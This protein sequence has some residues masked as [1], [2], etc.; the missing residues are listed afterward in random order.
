MFDAQLLFPG[1]VPATGIKILGPWFPKQ[2][3]HARIT[4]EV[5]EVNGAT[6]KVELFTKNSEDAGDGTN[7]DSGGV[8][9]NITA[10]ATGRTTQEWYSTG[11]IALKEMVRYRFTV[12][13]GV[14]S[15]WVLF[16][17]LSPVWFSAVKG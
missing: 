16:R 12:T 8:P 10:A 13:G 1:A 14:A 9:T 4:L 7:A 5:A 3:D 2:G 15:D 6:I 11:T 17:M